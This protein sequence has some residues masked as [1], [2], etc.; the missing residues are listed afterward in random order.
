[1]AKNFNEV[2]SEDVDNDVNKYP[3]LTTLNGGDDLRTD[4]K[5]TGA[6]AQSSV[7]AKDHDLEDEPSSDKVA[8]KPEFTD[9]ETCKSAMLESKLE[10]ADKKRER[11]PTSS[12]NVSESSDTSHIDGGKEVEKLSDPQETCEKDVRGSPRDEMSAEASKSLEKDSVTNLSSPKAPETE[13]ANSA[14]VSLSGSVYDES[15]PKKASKLKKKELSIQEETPSLDFVSEKASE[16]RNDSEARLH[17]RLAKK[18]PADATNE[19]KTSTDVDASENRGGKSDLEAK[20]IKQLSKKVDED[21]NTEDGYSL[22]RNRDGKK[23][24]HGKVASESEVNKAPAKDDL[25]VIHHSS[26][27]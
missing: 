21:S 27:M 17:R 7:N 8:M 14:S 25:K 6:G 5:G 2:C 4:C 11:K 3:K 18:A 19:G 12:I 10:D 20:K 13:G 9:S 23:R 16:V 15:L 24:G 22:K 1:M 26:R